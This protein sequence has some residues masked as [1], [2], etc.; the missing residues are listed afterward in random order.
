MQTH[1]EQELQNVKLKMFEMMDIVIESVQKSIEALKNLDG[2]LADEIIL[3]DEV[4]DQYEISIDNECVKVLVTKQPAASDLR[5]V[6]SILKINTDLE[7]IGDLATNIAKQVKIIQGQKLIKPLVDI[8][9]MAGICI[10]ML[11]DSFVAITEKDA[12]KAADIIKRDDEVDEIDIQVSRELLSFMLEDHKTISQA[13]SMIM[14]TKAIERMGDHIT[15]IAER[16]IYYIEGDD[17]R[18]QH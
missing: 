1:L 16:A 6:L 18:H 7:R 10:E 8:P 12:Q 14:V 11:K 13:L 4:I 9:R 15:N 17:I 3:K 2:K 5:L